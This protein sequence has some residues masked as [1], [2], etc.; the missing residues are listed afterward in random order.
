[1]VHENNG[2]NDSELINRQLLDD[3]DM[4]NQP[5]VTDLASP[6]ALYR[7]HRSSSPIATENVVDQLRTPSASATN[8]S[9]KMICAESEN[10][11]AIHTTPASVLL[12]PEEVVST[13]S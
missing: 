1:V 10:R 8:K 9:R 11:P 5:C 2:M 7:K 4:I 12:E 3:P 6:G 13:I